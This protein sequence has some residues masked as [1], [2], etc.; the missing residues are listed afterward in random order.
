MK[1]GKQVGEGRLAKTV[2]VMFSTD[3]TFDVGEDWGIPVVPT[4]RLPDTFTGV[5]PSRHVAPDRK[6]SAAPP[7]SHRPRL[8]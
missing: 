8:S 6:K 1:C 4:Y 3:D 5:L 2:P 7:S